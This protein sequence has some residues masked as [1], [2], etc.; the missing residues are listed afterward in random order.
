MVTAVIMQPTHLPWV[1]YFDLME[2]CDVFVFLDSVQFA[3]RSWQQ[4]NR[5]KTS[6]G[7]LLLTVPVVSKGLR[8]QRICDTHIDRA[9]EFEKKHAASIRAAYAKAPY[10]EKISAGYK[11]ITEKK[12]QMLADLNIELIEWLAN[13][14]GIERK[15]VR[16]SSLAV[17]GK[18]SEL[19]L[20]ICRSVGAD[21]YLSP[22]GSKEY[23]ED[24]ALMTQDRAI[25]L[26]FHEYA[27]VE[28][29]Q[30]HGDF[31]PSL[32][33][34]DLVMNQTSGEALETIKEGRTRKSS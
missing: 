25:E 27:P 15:T 9:V 19:L 3:R 29:P 34:I 5:I 1:G 16:S 20:E 32:S 26:L 7:E 28:Y 17:S 12:H 24:D 21:R 2:Q 18:R 30:L 8:E 4:R 22:L 6:Q 14:L 31:I 10:Y 33:A 23:L 11:L 13:I